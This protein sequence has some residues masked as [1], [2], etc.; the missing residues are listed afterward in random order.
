MNTGNGGQAAV[1]VSVP[2]ALAFNQAY[3]FFVFQLLRV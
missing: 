1:L 2:A 3:D